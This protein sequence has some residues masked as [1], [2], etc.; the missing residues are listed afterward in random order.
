MR[1]VPWIFAAV[2]LASGCSGSTD[3]ADGKKLFEATCAR[4]HGPDG[5]GDPL[6]KIKLGVPDMTAAAFQRKVTDDDIR[7]TVR[8]GSKSKKMPSFGTFYEP[9]QLDALVRYV[10]ALERR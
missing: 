7:R 10:R 1:L 5:T 6:Q 3:G 9:R 2:L 4:C 8:E